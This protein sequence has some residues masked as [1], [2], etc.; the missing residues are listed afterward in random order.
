MLAN[1]D[2]PITELEEL[3]KTQGKQN[4]DRK[5]QRYGIDFSSDGH[6]DSRI[7]TI[8]HIPDPFKV[9]AIVKL[10]IP[11]QANFTKIRNFYYFLFCAEGFAEAPLIEMER[12]MDA[13]GVPMARQTI[14]KWL[15]YLQHI[16]YIT[17]SADNIKYYVIRKNP[18]VKIVPFLTFAIITKNVS[19]KQNKKRIKLPFLS[20]TTEKKGEYF[21]CKNKNV[22]F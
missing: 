14:T 13:E 11:G 10:G 15:N 18:I 22:V 2:Y 1:R 3:L 4:I 17:F 16:D 5:L 19:I 9:Y 7:Y 12:I 21:L 8:K 20:Q 6:G